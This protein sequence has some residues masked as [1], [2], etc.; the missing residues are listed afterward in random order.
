MA[1]Q[2]DRMSMAD[3]PEVMAIER[4]SFL[5][6]WPGSAYKR[7]LGENRNAHYLVLRIDPP[8]SGPMAPQESEHP[9]QAQERRSFWSQ[10]FPVSRSREI[11]PAPPEQQSLAGYAGLWLMVDEAHITTI[12]VRPRFR[13]RGLGELL[14]VALAEIAYDINARWL[15]LEVRVSNHVAQALYRKYGFKPAGIRQ[16][17]YSD[18]QEDALIMWTDE[19][20]SPEWQERFEDLR[21]KLRQR[22]IVAGDLAGSAADRT[23]PARL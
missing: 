3:V 11:T 5:T 18:N 23:A 9:A 21:R 19:I 13:G 16:R 1:L 10:I 6:P 12:A 22:L 2:I 17:Y 8:Q 7:E 14:L 4:D 20:R 15:T